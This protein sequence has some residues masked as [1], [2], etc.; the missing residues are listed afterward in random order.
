MAT[1]PG[2][3]LLDATGHPL[4][5]ASGNVRIVPASGV[6][7][8][9]CGGGGGGNPCTNAA[10]SISIVGY[11]STMFPTCPGV[12]APVGSDCPWTGIFD[13]FDTSNCAYSARA[14]FAGGGCFDCSMNGM[15]LCGI[16]SGNSTPPYAAG[17]PAVAEGSTLTSQGFGGY[18]WVA[19]NLYCAIYVYASDGNDSLLAWAGEATNSGS[20]AT[21]YT[22]VAGCCG[23]PASVTLG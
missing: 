4:T 9:C 21:T 3:V 17:I 1:T 7:A 5:D 10:S 8:T 16:N 12:Q 13:Y 2:N 22:R 18:S 11:T 14:C 20:F 6:C 23:S 15:R 19:G